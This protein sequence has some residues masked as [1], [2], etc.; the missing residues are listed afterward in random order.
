MRHYVESLFSGIAQNDNFDY[1]ST[2]FLR[3]RFENIVSEGAHIDSVFVGCELTNV[4]WYW[5]TAF[6]PT[7]VD[8]TFSNCDLR[9][10]FF[11]GSF[12]SCTFH[13]CATG[14]D[15]LGGST[16]WENCAVTNCKLFDTVLPLVTN[17][18][19]L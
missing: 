3:C 6:S 17:E 18:E 8:C 15:N 19:S 13:K 5:C 7:F 10:S 4:D 16:E 2:V 14:D 1:L 12:I 9:G 11:S